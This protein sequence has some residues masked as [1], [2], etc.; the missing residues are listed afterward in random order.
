MSTIGAQGS[1]EH[2]LIPRV[3]CVLSPGGTV[4]LS[5]VADLQERDVH[6]SGFALALLWR[7]TLVAALVDPNSC[8]AL[9]IGR[10]T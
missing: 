7:V 5:P 1:A 3:L 10:W 6:W 8:T 2:A 9:V 4:C